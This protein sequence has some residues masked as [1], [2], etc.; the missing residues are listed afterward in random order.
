MEQRKSCPLRDLA[1]NLEQSPGELDRL[2]LLVL[3]DLDD[4]IRS[5][6]F[7]DRGTH[8]PDWPAPAGSFS[9]QGSGDE[10]V[11]VRAWLRRQLQAEILRQDWLASTWSE[12]VEERLSKGG[13]RL[14]DHRT[15]DHVPVRL[16]LAALRPAP[17]ALGKLVN[18]LCSV[19]SGEE[20]WELVHGAPEPARPPLRFAGTAGGLSGGDRLKAKD[21]RECPLNFPPQPPSTGCFGMH[22]GAR[23]SAS[24]GPLPA[25]QVVLRVAT[26]CLQVRREATGYKCPQ[27]P[28]P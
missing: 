2:G 9:P 7:I 20:R 3:D 22:P 15:G 21:F 13:I 25:P 1:R 14:P 8:I 10:R 18:W 28:A 23:D 17:E 5:V 4:R 24:R 12:A 6:T 16:G 11:A 19:D 26:T 27:I